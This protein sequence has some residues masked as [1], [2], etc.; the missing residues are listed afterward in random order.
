MERIVQNETRRGRDAPSRVD[1]T[2]T[3]PQFHKSGVVIG[4]DA[5]GE[6]VRSLLNN[7]HYCLSLFLCPINREK[8]TWKIFVDKD[9][10]ARTLKFPT[11]VIRKPSLKESLNLELSKILLVKLAS[12]GIFRML[13]HPFFLRLLS[14]SEREEDGGR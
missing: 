5:R 9:T 13:F 3:L 11:R 7:D 1:I 6:R 10:I 12:F 8:E 14:R 2:S 4:C